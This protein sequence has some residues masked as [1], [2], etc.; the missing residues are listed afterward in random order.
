MPFNLM[1]QCQYITAK[2]NNCPSVAHPKNLK[3]H[4]AG[5]E[6]FCIHHQRVLDAEGLTESRHSFSKNSSIPYQSIAS[7]MEGKID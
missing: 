4:V 7:L 6:K 1:T 2:G 3:Q 5:T